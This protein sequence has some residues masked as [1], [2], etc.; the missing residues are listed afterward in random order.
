M[1]TFC[2]VVSVISFL[3]NNGDDTETHIWRFK[4]DKGSDYVELIFNNKSNSYISGYYYGS[5]LY[6]DSS[7]IYYTS[8]IAA[9]VKT[10]DSIEFIVKDY[11]YFSKE[12]SPLNSDKSQGESL[13]V[14]YKLPPYLFWGKLSDSFLYLK[15]RVAYGSSAFESM[16]FERLR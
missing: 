14:N 4:K 11:K 2:I 10:A 9:T 8:V 15:K 6:K 7:V 16:K 5:L 13:G 3:L 12:I 1:K